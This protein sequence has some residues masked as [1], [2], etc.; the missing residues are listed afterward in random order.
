MRFSKTPKEKVHFYKKDKKIPEK[1][2]K[3][4]L[5]KQPNY[6]HSPFP[7]FSKTHLKT[8]FY[9]KKKWVM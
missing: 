5:R 1:L 6:T 3:N 8:R 4:C 7:Q 2:P 9:K